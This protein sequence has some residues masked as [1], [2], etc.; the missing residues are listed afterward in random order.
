MREREL[1][2][3]AWSGNRRFMGLPSLEDQFGGT[4]QHGAFRGHEE[5]HVW[6]LLFSLPSHLPEHPSIA[7]L[8]KLVSYELV[9]HF[10]NGEPPPRVH[11]YER[12]QAP[13]EIWDGTWKAS[14]PAMF[15]WAAFQFRDIPGALRIPWPCTAMV[16]EFAD[17][18]GKYASDF[19]LNP[20]DELIICADGMV[21]CDA[22]ADPVGGQ[23]L[24]HLYGRIT[25]D[26]YRA[27]REEEAALFNALPHQGSTPFA[28]AAMAG[29]RALGAKYQEGPYE[30][31]IHT[32]I[33]VLLCSIHA[34]AIL[35][36]W[37]NID[38]AVRQLGR[39]VNP[40]TG[41]WNF[42]AGNA[43]EKTA[44]KIVRDIDRELAMLRGPTEKRVWDGR[45]R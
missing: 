24:P 11:L 13:S 7:E 29:L 42:Y 32:A 35:C 21:R 26:Q 31:R 25:S 3:V 10:R 2:L 6:T 22:P 33:G 28:R 4:A 30:W 37:E 5:G 19:H 8:S 38:E 43:T 39:D 40:N 34:N 9:E 16:M 12:W 41:K 20:S 27:K 23:M 1:I 36:R 44:E 17:V 45:V 18:F 15:G 14:D